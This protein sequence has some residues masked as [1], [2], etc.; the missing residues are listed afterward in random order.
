MLRI[1]KKTAEYISREI[2]GTMNYHYTHHTGGRG[3]S[4]NMKYQ[5]I[6]P[7]TFSP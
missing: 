6:P 2:K 1:S 4:D 5:S 7:T 3:K